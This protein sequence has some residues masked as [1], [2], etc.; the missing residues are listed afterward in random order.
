M[1]LVRPAAVVLAVQP[2]LPQTFS[3]AGGSFQLEVPQKRRQGGRCLHAGRLLPAKNSLLNAWTCGFLSAECADSLFNRIPA[4][5]RKVRSL[6]MQSTPIAVE[7]WLTFLHRGEATVLKVHQCE[8]N[9]SSFKCI[10]T[11]DLVKMRFMGESPQ[12]RLGGREGT[13][14]VYVSGTTQY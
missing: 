5:F 14:D 9:P 12:S 13:V 1:A 11:K 7:D 10:G 2:K 8:L 6:P 3:L 4:R